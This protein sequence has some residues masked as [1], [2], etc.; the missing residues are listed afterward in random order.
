MYIT[1]IGRISIDKGFYRFI[2]AIN[3]LLN[4][5]RYSSL[6]FRIVSPKSDIKN[7]DDDLKKFLFNK[8]I[9]LSEYISNPIQYYAQSKI[10]VIPTTYGEGLSRVALEAGFL[11]VPIVAIQNR[12]LSS[13]F[14]D[15]VLGE[16]TMDTEPYGISRLIKKLI[17]NYSDYSY[18]SENVFKSLSSKYDNKVSANTVI[19]VLSYNLDPD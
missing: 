7:I 4:D 2:A 13:L 17:D 16:T 15:G 5:S 9:L 12:G 8:K 1:F 18:F 14:M 19:N 3:Y 11:G 10:I 6:K